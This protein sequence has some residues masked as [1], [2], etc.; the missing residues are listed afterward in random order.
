MKKISCQGYTLKDYTPWTSISSCALYIIGMKTYLKYKGTKTFGVISSTSCSDIIPVQVLTPNKGSCTNFLAEVTKG[1][2]FCAISGA[3]SSAILWD[4][5][6]AEKLYTFRDHVDDRDLGQV[7]SLSLDKS[8]QFLSIGYS[9]GGIQKWDFAQ[10]PHS[11]SYFDGHQASVSSLCYNSTTSLLASASS[12]TTIIIWSIQGDRGLYRLRGHKNIVTCIKFCGMYDSEYLV[13][14]SKDSSIKIWDLQSQ[15]CVHNITGFEREIWSFDTICDDKN[16]CILADGSDGLMHAF[17]LDSTRLEQAASETEVS[18][19]IA[20]P[21]HWEKYGSIQRQSKQR[22]Q[23]IIVSD[24]KEWLI[25]L[26]SGKL[27][28]LY[29]KRSE[30]A[31]LKRLKRRQKRKKE[32]DTKLT[33]DI[34]DEYELVKTIRTKVKTVAISFLGKKEDY[35]SEVEFIVSGAD[36]TLRV[37][38][39]R[40]VKNRTTDNNIHS[41]SS[42]LKMSLQLPGHRDEPRTIAISNDNKAVLSCSKDCIKLWDL[43]NCNALRTIK[44]PV[45]V[46]SP[47][48]CLFAPG[49]IYCIVGTRGG[50]I[51]VVNL[52]TARIVWS[53]IAHS[54]SSVWSLSLS[55]DEGGIASGASDNLVKFWDFQ[56]NSTQSNDK[57]SNHDHLSLFHTRTL[58]LTEDVLCVKNSNGTQRAKIA[59]AL[60]DCTVKVFFEDS[61]RLAFSLYGHQLPVIDMD[62]SSDNTLIVTG[63][64]DK[65]IKIW[66]MDFGDCH[67][68]IY[69]H[70]A[71]V[72][73]LSFVRS[74]HYVFSGGK[75]GKLRFWDVDSFQMISSCDAHNGELWCIAGTDDGSCIISSGSDKS[76]RKWLRTDEPLFLEEER[77]KA[78]ETQFDQKY[79]EADANT[80]APSSQPLSFI[81][82]EHASKRTAKSVKAGERLF[83]ALEVSFSYVEKLRLWR[84]R[85]RE[86]NEKQ[87][88]K[89]K[90]NDAVEDNSL[91]TKPP[92]DIRLL[93]RSPVKHIAIIINEIK[94]SEIEEALLTL[95]LSSLPKLFYFLN[96]MLKCRILVNVCAQCSIFVARMHFRYILNSSPLRPILREIRKNL[97]DALREVRDIFGYN[98]AAIKSEYDSRMHS[99]RF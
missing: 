73:S 74:T 14:S 43:E 85:K 5:R 81:E 61:L 36:N 70:D 11:V 76:I 90:M 69:A 56:L 52:I 78:R 30:E 29:L 46:G 15:C 53:S 17:R 57:S 23:H 7:T 13:S 49:D 28:E 20:M 77:E 6:T 33:R 25:C 21:I 83:E 91:P 59:V 1:R 50:V 92:P 60:L 26:T 55:P 87:G 34:S 47:L 41:Y 98:V 96:E 4:L 2:N 3:G 75:D 9:L 97:R 93:G 79:F 44:M 88:K 32:K 63:S 68:S 80:A 42:S 58:K 37:Y 66:G 71:S 95:P 27:I 24:S 16:T 10:D 89:E 48:C 62:I 86:V 72:T 84:E 31:A 67:H 39:V 18:N 38:S 65:N 99:T 22:V 54:N 45:K 8:R 64:A 94:H 40:K 82:S 19:F 35:D 12:D 51:L